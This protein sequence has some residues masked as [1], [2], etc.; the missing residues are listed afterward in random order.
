[1]AAEERDDLIV[2][3]GEPC[4]QERREERPGGELAGDLGCL[5]GQGGL[6]SAVRAVLRHS[7]GRQLPSDG[8]RVPWVSCCWRQSALAG[9]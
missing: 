1:M 4:L 9:L 2:A 5:A 8:R 7:S 6:L 3:G